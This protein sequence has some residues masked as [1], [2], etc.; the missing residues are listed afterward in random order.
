M[1][2]GEI[3]YTPTVIDKLEKTVPGSSTPLVPFE[4]ST[5][6]IYYLFILIM[7]IAL[8]NLLVSI[9]P[10]QWRIPESG[11]FLLADTGIGENLLAES[12]ILGFRIRNTAQ[13]VWNP[14]NDWYPQSKFHWKKLKSSSW[15]LE[16]GI[17]NLESGIWNQLR[18]IHNRLKEIL[19]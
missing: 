19:S 12:G 8:V 1:T 18:G 17:W 15:N 16:S 10:C 4:E 7:P 6:I 13:G 9:T 3:E 5:Y 14:T 2:T 11:K